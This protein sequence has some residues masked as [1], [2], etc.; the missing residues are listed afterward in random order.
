MFSS[1]YPKSLGKVRSQTQ[2]SLSIS[3]SLSQKEKETHE[4]SKKETQEEGDSQNR[5]RDG[6]PKCSSK[7]STEMK[8]HKT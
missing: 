8:G 1:K 5:I 6:G 3:V 4:G 7:A 2:E